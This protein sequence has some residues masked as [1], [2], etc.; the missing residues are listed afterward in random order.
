MDRIIIGLEG[1]ECVSSD[2]CMSIRGGSGVW[3]RIIQFILENADE[4]VE[5]FI[6][7]WNGEKIFQSTETK[8]ATT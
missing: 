4:L 5:G 3:R 8:T 2:Q 7:G 6:E 1:L